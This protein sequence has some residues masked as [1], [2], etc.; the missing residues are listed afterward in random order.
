MAAK[1]VLT[2]TSAFVNERS[3]WYNW[4][5]VNVGCGTGTFVWPDSDPMP[6]RPPIKTE[7]MA[8]DREFFIERRLFARPDHRWLASDA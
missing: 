4:A 3:G 7:E 2:P 8:V 1:V 6:V 5:V